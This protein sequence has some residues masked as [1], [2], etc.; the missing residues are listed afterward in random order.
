MPYFLTCCF[1]VENRIFSHVIE[2]DGG[3]TDHIINI[4]PGK[5][6]PQIIRNI[7]DFRR[8]E[9]NLLLKSMFL[10]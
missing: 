10:L 4:L 1:N 6:M 2:P 9:E 3:K 5:A 7:T 8:I